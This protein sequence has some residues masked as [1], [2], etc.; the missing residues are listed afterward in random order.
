MPPTASSR[1]HE[2]AAQGLVEGVICSGSLA[3]LVGYSH[4]GESL[5]TGACDAELTARRQEMAACRR[6][7]AHYDL[8][9]RQMSMPL[10]RGSRCPLRAQ[11]GERASPRSGRAILAAYAAVRDQA[12]SFPRNAKRLAALR[13]CRYDE[14]A[15]RV[16]AADAGLICPTAYTFGSMRLRRG[17]GTVSY[18]ASAR[19][20]TIRA[21]SSGRKSR[22]RQYVTRG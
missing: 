22:E 19:P 10:S 6:F 5:A 3:C 16:R 11:A 8:L 14:C 12:R 17:R 7:R 18:R 21:S 15:P 1:R 13:R 20:S 4:A 9:A 2:L